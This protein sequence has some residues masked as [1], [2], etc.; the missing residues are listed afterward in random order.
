MAVTAG[1]E[2]GFG[3]LTPL[4]HTSFFPD[5][6]QVNFFPEV[7]LVVPN[8]LQVVPGL[9]AAF[10]WIAENVRKLETSDRKIR[11]FRTEAN[12]L[13]LT[14]FILLNSWI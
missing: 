10:A 5:L 7:M 14:E 8:F 12:C 1:V 2:E 6:I 3:T 9:T 11:L 4:S 13:C